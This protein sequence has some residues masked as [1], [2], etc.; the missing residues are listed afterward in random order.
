MKTRRIYSVSLSYLVC[1]NSRHQWLAKIHR[2]NGSVGALSAK[3]RPKGSN[4]QNCLG[5]RSNGV[6]VKCYAI[7]FQPQ[8][9]SSI[10]PIRNH[11]GTVLAPRNSLQWLAARVNAG[12]ISGISTKS[13][14]FPGKNH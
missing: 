6:E 3:R 4:S 10:T 1:L 12:G 11:V 14:H 9:I 2:Q 5:N 7:R 13:N 8:D